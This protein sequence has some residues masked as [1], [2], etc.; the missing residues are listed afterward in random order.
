[1]A[2]RDAG[3]NAMQDSR[4]MKD[5]G[6][7]SAALII[8][9]WGNSNAR[10]WLCAADGAVLDA[11]RGLGIAGLRGDPAGIAAAFADMTCGWPDHLPALLAGVVG[12]SFGW[13]DAGYLP[14]PIAV[15]QI[16]S[17][18]VRAPT[19]ERAVWITPGLTCINAWG[20]PDT[21]RGE[22]LQLAG[23]AAQAGAPN[24]LVALPGTHCKWALV[25][26]GRVTGFH[27]AISGELFAL[28]RDH[29][30][31]VDRTAHPAP[32][33]PPRRAT[34]AHCCCPNRR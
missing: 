31:M 33:H 20:E 12:A 8:G 7:A 18:A 10:M 13:R 28:L 30:V 26:G 11:R 22:E 9:D 2:K 4:A 17:H 23:W 25:Q 19:N 32:R 5:G 21:M 24:A 16:G 6:M 27:C 14:C 29:S 34:S 15:D 1:M 3:R